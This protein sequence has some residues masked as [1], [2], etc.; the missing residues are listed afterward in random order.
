[1]EIK[2]QTM[3][4]KP[5]GARWPGT[6]VGGRA[7]CTVTVGDETFI[8]WGRK[9][10]RWRLV[11]IPCGE[12]RVE[13]GKP[14]YP[15]S[16]DSQ[17]SMIKGEK[18][19]VHGEDR[20]GPFSWIQEILG[21]PEGV[22]LA[23]VGYRG[24]TLDNVGGSRVMHGDWLGPVHPSIAPGTTCFIDGKVAYLSAEQMDGGELTN[25]VHHGQEAWAFDKIAYFGQTRGHLCVVG[26]VGKF[27]QVHFNGAVIFEEPL[28]NVEIHQ[29]SGAEIALDAWTPSR[30]ER[31]RITF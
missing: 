21:A 15:A 9:T 19:V 22:P 29:V 25:V 4:E 30:A 7:L 8:Q 23:V 5:E 20:W 16:F 10:K 31:V 3:G 11:G 17:S 26:R 6:V 27:W 12:I 24:H 2:R 14:L 28:L 13:Y 1:M 18:V